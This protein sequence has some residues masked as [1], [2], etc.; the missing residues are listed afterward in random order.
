MGYGCHCAEVY[1]TAGTTIVGSWGS[2]RP[3]TE[4]IDKDFQQMQPDQPSFRYIGEL[5]AS[6][7]TERE[8]DGVPSIVAQFSRQVRACELLD[9]LASIADAPPAALAQI[10]SKLPGGGGGGGEFVPRDLVDASKGG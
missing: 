5:D 4:Y 9:A 2:S 6:G 7:Y 3:G 10:V 1:V 8:V